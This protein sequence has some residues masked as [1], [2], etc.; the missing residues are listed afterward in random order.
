MKKNEAGTVFSGLLSPKLFRIMKMTLLLLTVA[1]LQV[2]ANGYSQEKITLRMKTADIKRVLFAIEKN[3]GYRFLFDED[4]VK[5]KP[6]VSV[7]VK[8]AP[9]DDVLSRIFSNTGIRYKI[10]NTNLVVLKEA[11]PVAEMNI[12]EV[13][14]AGKVT[15][16]TGVPLPGVSVTIKGSTVG[17]TTDGDGNYSLTVPD[18]ATLE[19]SYV[20]YVTIEQKVEGR[21]IINIVMLSAEK[22]LDAIVVVGYGTQ[23]KR[24]LTG[25]IAS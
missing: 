24:D 3:S 22:T 9:I 23:K 7:E 1:C 4:V 20:G 11:A 2:S 13:R 5:G 10:L 15:S 19:F 6:R 14:V 8:D 21:N 18:D 17:T 12:R 25:S 16:A